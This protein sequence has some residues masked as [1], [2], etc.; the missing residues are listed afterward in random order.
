MLSTSVNTCQKKKFLDIQAA[1][2]VKELE[3]PFPSLHGFLSSV[4]WPH[5]LAQPGAS[6]VSEPAAPPVAQQ[7]RPSPAALKTQGRRSPPTILSHSAVC[8]L[9][10]VTLRSSSR[11]SSTTAQMTKQTLYMAPTPHLGS[12]PC[13]V[14]ETF[15]SSASNFL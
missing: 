7:A 13:S 15:T 9:L 4:A 14:L 3:I 2:W 1:A 12:L 6:G 5:H 8:F 11:G 10:A